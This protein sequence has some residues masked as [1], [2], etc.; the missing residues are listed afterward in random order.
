MTAYAP[1]THLETHDVT[2]VPPPLTG[3]NLYA[4]D[5][6]LRDAARLYGGEWVEAPLLALGAAA[7]SEEVLQWG[8][9]ANRYPPEL[10][11]FDRF[12]RRV[13]EVK[14]HPAYH[15]LMALAMEHRIHSIGWAEKRPGPA[16]CARGA[17]GAPYSGG[18]RHHVPDQ[19]DLCERGSA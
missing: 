18:G 3:R 6:A 11:S 19:H 12:G 15:R 14:F 9:D 17:A 2:N 8:E 7:G 5:A 4:S 13:D 1:Q 16:C 10:Q